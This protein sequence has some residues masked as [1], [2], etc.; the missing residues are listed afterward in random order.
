MQLHQQMHVQLRDRRRDQR[1]HRPQPVVVH[2]IRRSGTASH[3]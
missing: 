1:E 3:R 2:L